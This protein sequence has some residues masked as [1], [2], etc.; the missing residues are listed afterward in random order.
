MH[1]SPVKLSITSKGGEHPPT[2]SK[3]QSHGYTLQ[4]AKPEPSQAGHPSSLAS[5]KGRGQQ[6]QSVRP[7]KVSILLKDSIVPAHLKSL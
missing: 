3:Q 1:A 5:F 7:R 6:P 2:H 4:L